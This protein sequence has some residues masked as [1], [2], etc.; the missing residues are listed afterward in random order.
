MYK[1]PGVIVGAGTAQGLAVTGFDYTWWIALG[2]TLLVA[3]IFLTR[4]A[5]RRTARQQR[6]R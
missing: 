6:S 4:V 1:F 3:G 5:A 2:M